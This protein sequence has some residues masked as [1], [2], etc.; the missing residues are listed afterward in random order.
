MDGL[1]LDTER[2]DLAFWQEVCEAHRFEYPANVH[3]GV[4]GL[5]GE[6]TIA[7]LQRV[8]G[9]TFPARSLQ[10]SVEKR[11]YRRH[12]EGPAPLRPGADAMIRWLAERK[13]PMA[14]ATSTRRPAAVLRLGDIA[15]R[16]PVLACGDE[17]A[18][19]KP[20]P[21]VYTLALARLGLTPAGCLAL[22][23]SIAGVEAAASAGLYVVT[24][25]DLVEPPSRPY[26]AE[27]LLELLSAFRELSCAE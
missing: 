7:E 6:E 25:P 1:L 13:I 19:H 20:A 24:I 5:N 2:M 14:I 12:Q 8:F 21:D 11:W 10:K 16:I 27:S 18:A 4:V 22:E 26:R 9:S 15:N 3:A 17:V 23:D